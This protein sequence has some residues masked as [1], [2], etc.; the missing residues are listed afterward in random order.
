MKEKFEDY[1]EQEFLQF[2]GD[3]LGGKADSDLELNQW[4]DHFDDITEHPDQSDVIFFPAEGEDES[5]Q[6]VLQRVKEWRAANGKPGF[7]QA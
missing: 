3:I 5:P 1:T 6:G 7:K 4:L 2:V